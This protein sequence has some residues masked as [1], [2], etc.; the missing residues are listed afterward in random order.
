MSLLYAFDSQLRS[1]DSG[2]Q[3]VGIFQQLYLLDADPFLVDRTGT[4]TWPIRSSLLES[5]RL[6]DFDLPTLKFSE[7]GRVRA[8]QLL[9]SGRR[10][11]LMWS[12][13]IDSTAMLVNFLCLGRSLAQVTVAMNEDSIREYPKFYQQHV[14]ENFDLMSTEELMLRA[15]VSGLDGV[16]LSAEHADQLFGSPLANTIHQRFGADYLLQPA[17]QHNIVTMMAGFGMHQQAAQCIHD[18]YHQTYA[19]SPRPIATTWDWLWWHGFNFKWQQIGQKLRTRLL[20]NVDLVTFYSS[21]DFQ[22]WSAHQQPDLKNIESLKNTAK[23]VILDHTQDQ[24]YFDQKIKHAS[25]TLYYAKPNSAAI[26]DQDQKISFD[27]F[28]V[29]DHYDPDN[30]IAKWLNNH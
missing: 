14:R 22:R 19:K 12:G 21:D 7:C 10:I 15:T 4:I 11:Y 18:L 26:T 24:E 2:K 5:H 16:M 9:D 28:H 23:Q 29:M 25:S 3:D 8:C 17:T 20:T 13:G 27:H 1:G 6:P 30:S